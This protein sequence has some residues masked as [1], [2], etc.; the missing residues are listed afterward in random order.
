MIAAYSCDFL[1]MW[2]V[3]ILCRWSAV[4]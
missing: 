1:C 3:W 2:Y 4:C